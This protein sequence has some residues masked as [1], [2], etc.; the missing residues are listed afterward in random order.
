MIERLN[1]RYNVRISQRDGDSWK[2]LSESHNILTNVGRTWLRDL[3]GV[4]A[5]P[6]PIPASGWIEGSSYV[7]TS[8]RIGWVAFGVGGSLSSAPYYASQDELVTVTAPEDWVQITATDYLKQVNV[9][10]ASAGSYPDDYTM[11]FHIDLQAGDIAFSGNTSKSGAAVG[12][13]VPVSEVML[14]L[15]GADK[16]NNPDHAT[17]TAR[18]VAYNIF[19][20]VTITPDVD[21]RLEWEF[22]F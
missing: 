5:Y 22:R 18:G 14:Y 3:I 20:P 10:S 16:T 21:I 19:S 8:E 1:P 4:I 9:Q 12:T 17:N 2:V 6:S 13:S 7:K 15:T 11:L